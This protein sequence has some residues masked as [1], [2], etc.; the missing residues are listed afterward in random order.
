MNERSQ[1]RITTAVSLVV[2]A[3]SATVATVGFFAFANLGRLGIAL[4]VKTVDQFRNIANLMPLVSELSSVMEPSLVEKGGLNRRQI[5]FAVSKIRIGGELVRSDFEGNPP[6]DLATILE[7]LRLIDRDLSSDFESAAPL[8]PTETILVRNRVDYVFSELRDY[9]LRINNGT[10]AALEAQ[11]KAMEAQRRTLFLSSLMSCVAVVLTLILLASRERIFSKLEKSRALAEANSTAKSEFLSNMSHEIRT[12][13]NAIIGLSYLA[14]KTN[15]TP[16]QRDYLKRIQVSSQHLL[17]V[18]NDI[19]DFSKIEARKLTVERV[20]F[21]LEKV[22]D[23]VAALTAEKAGAKGLELIFE[24]DKDVPRDLEGD[25]LR[26]GQILINYA[27]NAVKFT[28]AGEIGIRIRVAEKTATDVLLHFQVTDTGVGIADDQKPL[29]FRSFQQADGSITRR[30]GGSGL[31]LAISKNLAEMMGGSVGFESVLGK[32][33]TFWFTARLGIGRGEQSRFVPRSDLRGRRALVVDDN[34][35]ARAVILDMLVGMTF[36]SSAVASGAAAIEEVRRA[37]G[38]NAPYDLVFLDWQMP[39]LDGIETARRIAALGLARAPHL[40]IITAYGREEV[41]RAAEA[42][43]VEDVLIKPISASLL[44]DTAVHLLGGNRA[45]RQEQAPQSAPEGGDGFK[46]ARVLLAEDNEVNEEVAREILEQAGCL[47]SVAQD[48]AAAVDAVSSGDFDLVLMD[49]Q[50]P[51]M[52]GLAATRAIR[53]TARGGSLPIIA[54][55]ANAMAEDRER[56]MEA[57]MTDYVTKPIDPEALFATLRR[58]LGTAVPPAAVAIDASQLPPI[59]GIDTKAGLRRVLGNVG[60]YRDLLRRFIAGQR[61]A[62]AKIDEALS[63]DRGLAE[64]LAHTLKGVSGNIGALEIQSVA[65]ELEAAISGNA[66]P[67]ALVEILGRLEPLLA[68][69]VEAVAAAI[70]RSAPAAAPPAAH[71]GE[72]A[73]FRA[74]PPASEESLARLRHFAE[75]SDGETVDYFESLR[76]ELTVSYG[77]GAVQKLEAAIRS[78]DFAAAIALLDELAAGRGETDR[79]S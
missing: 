5:A 12:P 42:A 17:G 57:G 25:P 13:M 23:N 4:P 10:L 26:L 65:A 34:D 68:E 29:L 1:F 16:S 2:I 58:Y 63:T 37:A 33:S 45:E 11:R 27:N 50:M 60:L 18:I 73:A 78:Y 3:F 54:M 49:I 67:A 40:V 32:G 79:R 56:C 64:R 8:S 9:I 70:G 24:T 47:V 51:V 14:L 38:E 55:T 53:K 28:E 75:E 7:E 36:V 21:E 74:V 20:P 71:P 19:L 76:K 30:Y 15:L 52:D 41:I 22:M 35:H 44:F 39:N 6:D 77:D 66:A 61:E 31:G 72:P 46:G 43:G 48:G 62:A 59:R 69:T